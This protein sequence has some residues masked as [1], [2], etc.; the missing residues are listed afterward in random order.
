MNVGREIVCNRFVHMDS[1]FDAKKG[2]GEPPGPPVC[3]CAYEIDSSGRVI[4]HRLKAPYPVVPPWDH[5]PSDPYVAIVF[6]GSAEAGSCMHVEWPFPPLI[7]D[8]YAEYMVLHNTEMVRK[9]G[10]SGESKP[11]GPSLIKACQRYRV[12]AMDQDVKDD[13]RSL[14]YT[15]TDHTPEEIAG[16]QDYCLKD[17]C[18]MLVRLFKAMR[19]HIDFLRAPIRGAYMMEI[20]RM[21]WRG[22]PIDTATYYRTE[23]RGAAIASAMRV[24]LNQKLIVEAEKMRER[25]A[26]GKVKDTLG[27][28]LTGCAGPRP[29]SR[30]IFRTCLSERPCSR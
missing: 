13:M 2:T 23:K 24:E 7:V 18:G 25:T 8:L 26:E 20:E 12:R 9:A 14:A 1:E 5:G 3:F 21:R 16:L 29:K 10:R 15:K 11:P 4:E 6:A 30:S 22:I 17:D 19:P 28:M 27:R